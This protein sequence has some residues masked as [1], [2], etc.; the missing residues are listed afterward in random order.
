MRELKDP[1]VLRELK[2]P[3]VRREL[4]GFKDRRAREL[5]GLQDPKDTQELIVQ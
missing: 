3:Q 4:W 2:D 1:R 5:K